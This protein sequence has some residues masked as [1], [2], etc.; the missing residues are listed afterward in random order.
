MMKNEDRWETDRE[1][2]IEALT[3]IARDQLIRGRADCIINIKKNIIRRNI[4]KL[5][6][7]KVTNQLIQFAYNNEK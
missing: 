5:I 3:K 1:Q 6:F 2:G 7:E 4:M